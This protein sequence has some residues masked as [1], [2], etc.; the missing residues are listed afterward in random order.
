MDDEISLEYNGETYTTS[1]VV[2]G[3]SITLFLPGG[4][5]IITTRGGLSID[6]AL[7]PHFLKYLKEVIK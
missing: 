2:E 3:D 7:K 1:Y 6:S 4:R 5:Q